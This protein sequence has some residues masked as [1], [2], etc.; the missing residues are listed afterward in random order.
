MTLYLKFISG[1]LKWPLTG[2]QARM[3]GLL[4]NDEFE[5]IEKGNLANFWVLYRH[6]G[7]LDKPVQITGHNGKN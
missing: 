7:S 3:E 5:R 1:L 4:R 6:L 2:I